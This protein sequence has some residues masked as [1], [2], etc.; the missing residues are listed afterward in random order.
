MRGRGTQS[1]RAR[2]VD[3]REAAVRLEEEESPMVANDPIGSD[4]PGLDVVAHDVE[5][6][7][8]VVVTARAGRTVRAPTTRAADRG[9][10]LSRGW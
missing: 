5:T 10:Y 8:A 6:G 7:D 3:H 2:V 1:R 9:V 4:A